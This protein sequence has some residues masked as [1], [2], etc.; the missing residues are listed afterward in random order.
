MCTFPVSLW[1]RFFDHSNNIT[2]LLEKTRNFRAEVFETFL[3]ILSTPKIVLFFKDVF[4]RHIFQISNNFHKLNK[5]IDFTKM[6]GNL[7]N[8]FVS[9]II[10][11]NR[12]YFYIILLFSILCFV[13]IRLKIMIVEK[14]HFRVYKF[15]LVFMLIWI[16]YNQ[17]I[18]SN[19]ET[20]YTD[21]Y[22]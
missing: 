10:G 2:I 16:C 3:E 22:N 18:R 6:Q 15:L 4:Y 21:G 14:W 12:E 7:L 20:I 19:F 17:K 11:K 13:V 9:L 5:I 8:F 1:K